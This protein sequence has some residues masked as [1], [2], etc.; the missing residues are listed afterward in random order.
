MV[1]HVSWHL[2]YKI[3]EMTGYAGAG[4]AVIYGAAKSV[5]SAITKLIQKVDIL[6]CALG[7]VPTIN[8]NVNTIMTNHLPHLQTAVKESQEH[9][10]TLRSEFQGVVTSVTEM[11]KTVAVLASKQA[12][13]EDSLHRF[14][15]MFVRHIENAKN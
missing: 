2:V 5:T 10:E 13:N 1:A 15:E 6:L 8:Q 14:G 7:D 4:V 12:T 3:L 11:D 9:F